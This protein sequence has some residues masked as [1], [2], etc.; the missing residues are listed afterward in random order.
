MKT[1]CPECGRQFETL[2]APGL[3][4]ACPHCMARFLIGAGATTA[5]GSPAAADSPAGAPEPPLAVGAELEG[6]T[7]TAFLGQGGMGFVYKA[8]QKDLGRTVA[9]KIMS[10]RLVEAPEFAE[11]FLREARALAALNHPN[12][13][14]VYDF[15]QDN[16][17][18]YFVMEYVD[19]VSLREALKAG[20]L[21]PETALR[22]V[23]QICDA[24]QYAHAAG[25][26]HR[27]I[28]PE[29]ILLDR[30]G[31]LKIADFG[32][33]KITHPHAPARAMTATHAVMGT[34]H[35]MAPEQIENV[36]R[37]DHRADI[38]SLGVVFYEMLTGELPLGVFE[39]PSRRVRIDV[40]LDDVVLKALEKQ[41]DRR[42]QRA[43]DVKADVTRV[44]AGA[45]TRAERAEGD[46]MQNA[47]VA[48]TIQSVK[49][50]FAIL[51][52]AWWIAYP[53]FIFRGATTQLLD[54]SLRGR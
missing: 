43:G 23:P 48:F 38:Y 24:L 8:T 19:G 18:F 45:P 35:Y 3:K 13:V 11:R 49:T 32:L 17:L 22:Y 6:M 25:I 44:A 39:P 54:R 12:I 52:V 28:K 53:L 46:K 2:V 33:A 26:I 50:H 14:Q 20:H 31:N 9:V 36:A 1:T 47:S 7:I 40:R 37:V 4:E 27:D 5:T 29:N 16:G 42:Y 21:T 41:P 51:A 10:P 15:G 30:R 34:P